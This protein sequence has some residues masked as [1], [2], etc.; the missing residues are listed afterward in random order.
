[1]SRIIMHIDV[2]SAY[3]S[4][5]AVDRLQHG[6]PVDLRDIPSVVGGNEESRHGI[7]LAKSIP[8]KKYNIQTG[9][10]LYAARKKCPNLVSVPPRYDLY[11][12]CSKALRE[13]LAEYSDAIQ[14]FSVDECFLDYTSMTALLGDPVAVADEIRA[15]CRQ[16][17]GFTVNVGISSSKL[18]A[19]MAG[20]LKKPD[21]T[22]TLYPDEI[23]SKLWPLPVEELY[24]VG[25]ATAPK[26][27]NMGIKTIG[28]LAQTNLY[29]L[30]YSFKKFGVML[31]QYAN[32]IEATAVQPSSPMVKGVG[33]STTTTRNVEDHEHADMILLSLCESVAA[34]LRLGGW[35]ARLVAVSI[36]DTDFVT[37]SR[38]R[39]LLYATDNTTT[40]YNEVKILFRELWTGKPLRH[41]GIRTSQLLPA[42]G[43]QC[44]LFDVDFERKQALDRTIDELRIRYGKRSVQR[45]VFIHSGLSPVTGGVGEDDYQMMNSML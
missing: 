4:W 40:L 12:R 36:R 22:I 29:I 2:N 37:K 24:M 42:D 32:G 7:V 14:V 3:L 45:G 23:P 28:D 6:D 33:N 15:R 18:L 21:Q 26:L 25:R 10:S 5:E 35:C 44:S 1:M 27:H 11:M 8:A 38:Q 34:R 41:L 13:L 20:E 9:E 16:E 17:L 31:W 19:K 30:T 43:L 39:T